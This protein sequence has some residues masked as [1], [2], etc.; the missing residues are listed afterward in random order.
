M[1]A[2]DTN[3]EK[4]KKR[5]KGPL[6]GI[7]AVVAFALVLLAGWIAWEAYYGETPRDATPAEGVIPPET[8]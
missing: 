5:H 1:S 2:P 6:A 8:E 4:Q 7:A 3:L